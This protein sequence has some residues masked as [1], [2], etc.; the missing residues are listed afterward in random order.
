MSADKSSMIVKLDANENPYGMSVQA[1]KA[2]MHTPASRYPDETALRHA[3]ANFYHLKAMNVVVGSGSSEV[4]DMIARTFLD[5]EYEAICSQYAFMLYEQVTKRAGADTVV[6]A[7]IDFGHDLASM[8]AA[9]TPK[10]RVMWIANPNN[11]TGTFIRRDELFAQLG[12]VPQYVVVVLDEAYSE[13]LSPVD[14]SD[15][16]EIIARFPNVVVVR[17]FSKAYGLAGLRVG[18][19]LA[20]ERLSALVAN[21]KLRFDVNSVGLV[22]AEAALADRTF[23]EK[24]YQVNIAGRTQLEQ[25]LQIL[26]APYLSCKGNFIT[27]KVSNAHNVSE[28]LRMHGVIVLPLAT[29]GMVDYIR[30]TIGRPSENVYFLRVLEEERAALRT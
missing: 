30:V 17:T 28:R 19:S 25:G 10:T 24:S 4:L 12:K 2:M 14:R 15:A 9:I 7:A 5:C 26:N 16:T 23:I 1:R 18:Y 22:A 8:V 21:N 13:Y 11:P 20:H 6:V 29:Y 27:C 3:I